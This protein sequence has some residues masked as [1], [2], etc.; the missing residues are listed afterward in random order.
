VAAGEAT[1]VYLLIDA[2]AESEQ[3]RRIGVLLYWASSNRE[4]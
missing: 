1:R 3:M 4:G 2:G